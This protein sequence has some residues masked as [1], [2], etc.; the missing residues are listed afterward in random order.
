MFPSIGHNE[1]VSAVHERIASALATYREAILADNRERIKKA[2][3]REQ[4]IF[5]AAGPD[6][7]WRYD[8]I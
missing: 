5:D 8:D 4:R 3:E 7:D 2:L 6:I 1:L